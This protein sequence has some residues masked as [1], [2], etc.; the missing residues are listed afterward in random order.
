MKRREKR[1]RWETGEVREEEEGGEERGEEWR[2]D[3]GR[4]RREWKMRSE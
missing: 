3:E 4:E 1:M 2:E